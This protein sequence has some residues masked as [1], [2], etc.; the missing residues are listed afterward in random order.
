M[1]LNGQ[2]YKLST[3]KLHQVIKFI[4]KKFYSLLPE[5]IHLNTIKS[6]LNY[7]PIHRL[8]HSASCS[9]SLSI[10]HQQLIVISSIISQ[11]YYFHKPIYSEMIK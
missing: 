9:R 2:D 5:T 10:D 1:V 8:L 4:Q 3:I 7:Q 11:L 6:H